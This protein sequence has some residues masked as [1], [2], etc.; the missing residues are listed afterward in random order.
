MLVVPVVAV[1]TSTVRVVAIKIITG[2]PGRK[3][4][5]CGYLVIGRPIMTIA[6]VVA[7]SGSPVITNGP[8]KDGLSILAMSVLAMSGQGPML[9]GVVRAK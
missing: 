3:R 4:S 1:V 9:T 5:K 6:G 8:M 2:T 7:R